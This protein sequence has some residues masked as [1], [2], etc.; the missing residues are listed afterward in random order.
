MI[1]PGIGEE[2][3][4]GTAGELGARGYGLMLVY[5]KKPEET[6]SAIDS[7]GWLRSGDVSTMREDG[8]MRF[9]GRSQ[10]G[11]GTKVH[12]RVEGMGKP[13]AFV[14]TPGQLH[15]ATVFEQSM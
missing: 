13:V 4:F 7:G 11:L 9:I 10:G 12:L 2:L 3:P 1:D 15:E 6:A 5:F 8:S 14:L